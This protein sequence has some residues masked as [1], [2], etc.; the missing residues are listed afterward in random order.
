MALSQQEYDEAQRKSGLDIHDHGETVELP[1]NASK[2]QKNT[3]E[4]NQMA[5][6]EQHEQKLQKLQDRIDGIIGGYS[7]PE[8]ARILKV[9]ESTIYPMLQSGDLVGHK[10]L[11]SWRIKEQDI[12]TWAKAQAS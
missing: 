12:V 5:S 10:V 7:V 2:Y 11:G 8:A 6:E 4:N 1:G 3:K 9:K